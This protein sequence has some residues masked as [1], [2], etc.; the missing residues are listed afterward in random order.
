MLFSITGKRDDPLKENLKTTLKHLK[1]WERKQPRYYQNIN[2][3]ITLQSPM[4]WI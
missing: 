1:K 4:G 3:L 2:N